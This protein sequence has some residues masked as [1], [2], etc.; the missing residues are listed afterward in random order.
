MG[1]VQVSGKNM[2]LIQNYV[3]SRWL[4]WFDDW[5]WESFKKELERVQCQ[6]IPIR[7]DKQIQRTLHV[8]GFTALDLEQKTGFQQIHIAQYNGGPRG[9]YKVLVGELYNQ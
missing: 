9:A 8:N 1:S 4:Y 7:W 2:R 3:D 5:E 6:H